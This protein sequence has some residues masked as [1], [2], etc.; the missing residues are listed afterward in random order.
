MCCGLYKYTHYQ[1]TNIQ[2]TR[3]AKTAILLQLYSQNREKRLKN[4]N[5]FFLT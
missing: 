4:I 3:G 5:N 1:E 2:R